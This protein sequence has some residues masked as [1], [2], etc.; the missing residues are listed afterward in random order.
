MKTM[1]YSESRRNYAKTLQTVTDD[2]E[3]VIITRKGHEP[4]V[5]VPFDEYQAL[6]ETAYLMKTPA[7]HRHLMDSINEL[8][9]GNTKNIE[10]KDLLE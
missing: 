9:K 8:N 2:Q 5:I 10:I 6:K 4:V 1:S 3:E 7:N